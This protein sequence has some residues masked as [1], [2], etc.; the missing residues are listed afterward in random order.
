MCLFQGRVR[1]GCVQQGPVALRAAVLAWLDL[2]G[3]P[4]RASPPPPARPGKKVVVLEART[5]GAGQTGRT[6]A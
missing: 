6:T 4:R 3:L 1:G 2:I 5:R